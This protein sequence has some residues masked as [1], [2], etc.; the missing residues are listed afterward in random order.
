MESPDDKSS[1]MEEEHA[2]HH[3][4]VIKHVDRL[5]KEDDEDQWI[6]GEELYTDGSSDEEGKKGGVRRK[7]KR[8]HKGARPKEKITCKTSE[9][10]PKP[11]LVVPEHIESDNEEPIDISWKPKR[12]SIKLPHMTKDLEMTPSTTSTSAEPIAE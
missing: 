6:S 11:A 1:S 5:K 9:T 7:H 8:E 4:K 3:H 10:V 12:G 2:E